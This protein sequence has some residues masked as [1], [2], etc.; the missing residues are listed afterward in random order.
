MESV[1]FFRSIDRESSSAA[2]QKSA[3]ARRNLQQARKPPICTISLEGEGQ[4]GPFFYRCTLN[5]P[6]PS[7]RGRPERSPR[8]LY[9]CHCVPL[10]RRS[11]P[12]SH[13]RRCRP[14][15]ISR[16]PSGQVSERASGLF[17]GWSVVWHGAGPDDRRADSRRASL[18]CERRGGGKGAHIS[19]SIG[20]GRRRDDDD[21]RNTIDVS[22][23]CVGRR[24]KQ[25]SYLQSREQVCPF[26]RGS[27]GR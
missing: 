21:G 17:W 22:L 11:K 18:E 25:A 13:H 6:V 12:L 19:H 4:K 27:L 23:R 3:S 14:R 24:G 16:V 2:T 26:R 15:R 10:C 8:P 1:L 9:S 5:G 7:S 20:R